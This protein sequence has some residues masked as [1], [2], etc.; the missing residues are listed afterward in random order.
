[1]RL[2][3]HAVIGDPVLGEVIGTDALGAVDGTDLRRPPLGGLGVRGLRGGGLEPGREHLE[4]ALLVLQL[5]ALVLTRDDGAG[6]QVRDADRRVGGVD[7]LPTLTRRAVDVDPQIRLIDLD[8]AGIL[9]LRDHQHPGSRGVHPALGLGDGDA[10]HPVHAALELQSRPDA[11]PRRLLRAD[12]K[13]G[14]LDASE[15]GLGDPEH[16]DTPPMLLGVPGVHAGK[17]RGEQRGLLAALPG[18][19]LHHHVVGV[20]G[21]PRRKQVGQA[22]LQLGRLGVQPL[23]LLSKRGVVVCQLPRGGG[24]VPSRHQRPIALHDRGQLGETFTDTAGGRRVLVQRRIR[25]LRLEAAVLGEDVVDRR[26]RTPY[27]IAHSSSWGS[28][29]VV[30]A[31][32][33]RNS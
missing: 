32:C 26:R 16:L 7:A 33:S 6:G 15:I 11:V 18:L 5:T 20:M 30:L 31:T 13:R 8:R 10:L 17:V 9:G 25:Q 21:I 4:R 1:M 14:V 2:E 27:G 28:V 22:D 3:A 12:G 29:G 19:D 23:R 24:V